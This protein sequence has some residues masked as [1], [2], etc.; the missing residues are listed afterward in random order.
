MTDT[1]AIRLYV[2]AG[3]PREDWP[4]VDEAVRLPFRLEAEKQRYARLRKQAMKRFEKTL[5]K[6][7]EDD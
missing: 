6:L 1:E 7:A 3:N 2:A 4:R 5:A